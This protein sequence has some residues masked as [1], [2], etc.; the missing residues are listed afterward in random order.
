MYSNGTIS[1]FCISFSEVLHQSK[2]LP[3][4]PFTCESYDSTKVLLSGIPKNQISIHSPVT[5]LG[6]FQNNDNYPS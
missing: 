3:E 5:L 4:S 6:K 1:I 2:P